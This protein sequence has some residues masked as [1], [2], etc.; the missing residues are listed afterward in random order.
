ML[1]LHPEMEE[2][3]KIYRIGNFTHE[4]D[5]E[6]EVNAEIGNG[7][8]VKNSSMSTNSEKGYTYVFVTFERQKE[9]KEID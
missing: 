1:Y 3:V 5:V 9:T 7:W 2:K 8:R 6:D 4:D